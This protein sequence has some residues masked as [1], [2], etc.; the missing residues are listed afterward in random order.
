M[1][2]VREAAAAAAA[3]RANNG[4]AAATY[5]TGEVTPEANSRLFT[6]LSSVSSSFRP[7]V[8]SKCVNFTVITFLLLSV[9][10]DEAARESRSG[11]VW[12]RREN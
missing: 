12:Q 2:R 6:T 8:E 1:T 10:A 5:R 3:S 11:S 7:S 4:S 9:D